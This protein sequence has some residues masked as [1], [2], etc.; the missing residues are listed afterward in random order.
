M[1]KKKKSKKGNE[2]TQEI[3]LE[4]TQLASENDKYIGDLARFLEEKIEDIKITREGNQLSV[5]I[6]K[7]YSRRKIRDFLKKF[8]YL[9]RLEDVY[10][11]IA[12]Q[13]S[14]KGYEIHSRPEY[15]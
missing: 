8:L 12:L 4:L 10:R 14:E 11:P 13:E 6:E 5:V 2:E 15:E 7:D 1:A 9:A 3:T